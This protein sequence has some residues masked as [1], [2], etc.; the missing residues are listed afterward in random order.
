VAATLN[1]VGPGLD[2]VGAVRD[3]CL[4][5]A[6]GKVVLSLCMVIGRLELFSVLVLFVPGFWR[7]S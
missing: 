6:A 3:Y 7:R 4:I 2:Q 1:G 5:P